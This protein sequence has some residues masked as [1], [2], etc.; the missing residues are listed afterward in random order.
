[1]AFLKDNADRDGWVHGV[2]IDEIAQAMGVTR[3]QIVRYFKQIEAMKNLPILIVHRRGSHRCNSYYLP[4]GGET[5][6]WGRDMS[7]CNMTEWTTPKGKTK[8]ARS[9]SPPSLKNPYPQEEYIN[10]SKDSPGV[11]GGQQLRKGTEDYPDGS[12]VVLVTGARFYRQVMKAMR[13]GLESWQ[14]P[15]SVSDAL[16]G[17]FGNRIDGATLEYARFLK[18]RIW[19]FRSDVERMAAS[20]LSA[21]Q[22][23][24]FVSGSILAPHRAEREV[25]R[26]TEAFIGAVERIEMRI[27]GLKRWLAERESEYF[28]DR[29][30]ARCGYRHSEI[31]H[32]TGYRDD[33]SGTFVCFGFARLKLDELREELKLAMRRESDLRCSLCHKVL[34][35][36]EGFVETPQKLCWGC[37]QKAKAARG[38]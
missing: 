27:S 11:N 7:G 35:A 8:D 38:G 21:R 31:E 19:S 37:Y 20:G 28:S 29:V 5:L 2:G 17:W 1:M 30:C 22:I 23:V 24:S 33:G 15:E 26:R 14:I 36:H 16:E 32:R 10:T 3:A 9:C 25:S 13:L 4:K 34:S 18:E 6:S 12:K